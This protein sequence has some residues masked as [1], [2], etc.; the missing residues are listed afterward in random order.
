MII[1]EEL[2]WIFTDLHNENARDDDFDRKGGDDL[3]SI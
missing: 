1:K 3:G 2:Q